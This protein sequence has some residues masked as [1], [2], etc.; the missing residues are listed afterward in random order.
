LFLPFEGGL[1]CLL[2]SKQR[3]SEKSSDQT[4]RRQINFKEAHTYTGRYLPF[5]SR[6]L[7]AFCVAD[8]VASACVSCRLEQIFSQRRQLYIKYNE[9]LA[10]ICIIF[11]L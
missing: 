9:I 6:S 1:D 4:I 5:P 3:D 8:S 11:W 2:S 7:S 10:G